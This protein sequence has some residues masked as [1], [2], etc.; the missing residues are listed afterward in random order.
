LWPNELEVDIGKS[1]SSLGAP[2]IGCSHT[3]YASAAAG[4]SRWPLSLGRLLVM[5][6]AAYEKDH[7]DAQHLLTTSSLSVYTMKCSKERP[8]LSQS[9]CAR[10]RDGTFKLPI[11]AMLNVRRTFDCPTSTPS[12]SK[13]FYID[14][15]NP[16]SSVQSVQEPACFIPGILRVHG[17]TKSL[18]GT[19]RDRKIVK[20]GKNFPSRRV[21]VLQT[22]E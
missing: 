22:N 13:P 14:L 6:Q 21:L 17:P 19:V 2:Q 9:I 4:S 16:F 20:S 10:H 3:T 12:S 7:D 1:T 15:V 18:L 8:L 5:S 11:S